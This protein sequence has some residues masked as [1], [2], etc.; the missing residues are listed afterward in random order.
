[1]DGRRKTLIILILILLLGSFLRFF[2]LGAESLWSDELHTWRESRYHHLSDVINKGA[3][4][5]INPPGYLTLI[6]F[7]QKFIGESEFI[8]RFPS[9]VSGVLSIF[10]I[11]LLGS[12]LYTYREGLI[13]AV[14]LVVLWRP[15]YYSQEAR[16]YSLLLLFSLLSFYLWIS[17]IKSLK[18]NIKPKFYEIFS[19]VVSGIILCYLHYFGLYLVA[20][21]A[22]G[23]FLML[24]RHPKQA[25]YAFFIW[26]LI[27]IAYLPWLPGMWQHLNSGPACHI[28]KPDK[29]AFI[30]CFTFFF[31]GSTKLSLIVLILY[32]FLF[33]HSI[34]RVFR[35]R[36]FDD[37]NA[38]IDPTLLLFLWLTIPFFGAFIMSILSTPV[39]QERNLIISLPAA[40]LLLSRS[41]TILPLCPRNKT[42]IVCL[43]VSL[44]LFHLVFRIDYYTKPHK[45]QFREGVGFIV[46]RENQYDNA[47]IIGYS[48]EKEYFDYYFKRLGSDNR[49]NIIAGEEKDIDRIAKIIRE[50]RPSYSYI[51]YITAH[52]THKKNPEIFIEFMK[53][54]FSLKEHRKFIKAEVRLFEMGC[55]I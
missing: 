20:L 46:N 24:I 19:Y 17:I 15:I 38:A 32:S 49:V 6:H 39:L 40:C 10:I 54:N 37:K 18:E 4:P 21:Q 44:F 14:L 9:A 23:A 12:R 1:M 8:L 41:L 50:K 22:L 53:K 47:L 55:G 27:L 2:H 35:N 43:M 51:W 52:M 34:Y 5:G 45:Q 28:A 36:E 26:F 29:F 3:R 48:W 11:F 16:S 42:L 30:Q 31:N 25:A 13:S 7:V 33:V